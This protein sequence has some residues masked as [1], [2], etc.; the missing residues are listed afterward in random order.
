MHTTGLNHDQ[1]SKP[2][3]I[4]SRI[5]KEMGQHDTEMG[6]H[7]TEDDRHQSHSKPS[8]TN[9]WSFLENRLANSSPTGFRK[10]TKASHQH[11]PSPLS[12]SQP[13]MMP[14]FV[15]SALPSSSQPLAPSFQSTGQF[16]SSTLEQVPS[17]HSTLSLSF[18]PANRPALPLHHGAVPT[19]ATSH[20][21]SEASLPLTRP[22]NSEPFPPL[23]PP[24]SLPPTSL[25]FPQSFSATVSSASLPQSSSEPF[26][27]PPSS[28]A[29]TSM[30][31]SFPL[32]SKTKYSPP[33][34]RHSKVPTPF[35]NDSK[36]KQHHLTE[37]VQFDPHI[38]YVS[39]Q[40]ADDETSS[41]SETQVS[42]RVHNETTGSTRKISLSSSSDS[43]VSP[44]HSPSSRGID[45]RLE[46]AKAKAKDIARST[47]QSAERLTSHK[48][49]RQLQQGTHSNSSSTPSLSSGSSTNVLNADKSALTSGDIDD[50]H[51][52]DVTKRLKGLDR[53]I[54]TA[55]QVAQST[56]ESVEKL[57]KKI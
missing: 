51:N 24:P 7:D 29:T 21:I 27:F 6:Q 57:S 25:Y 31:S 41:P 37:R 53:V 10:T 56:G 11:A 45:G 1:S 33:I 9:E 17:L 16:V 39:A 34:F 30:H 38:R 54:H 13:L 12:N 5:N 2:L 48:K 52:D 4:G 46:K 19:P 44:V 43:T 15:P 18:T 26:S 40:S 47:G 55:E 20:F 14:Q 50:H 32:A 3:R 49:K 22:L 42:S 35:D 23:H 36:S 28:N 8:M